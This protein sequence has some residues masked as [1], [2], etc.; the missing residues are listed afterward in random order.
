MAK[1]L[2]AILFVIILDLIVYGTAA[3]LNANPDDVVGWIALGGVA[4]ILTWPFND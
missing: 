3:I 4:G 1:I 2:L